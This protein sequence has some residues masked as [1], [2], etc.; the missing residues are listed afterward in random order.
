MY[1]RY[2]GKQIG[3]ILVFPTSGK[4]RAM[5]PGITPEII[6]EE[7]GG[8]VVNILFQ[9]ATYCGRI[10]KGTINLSKL[11]TILPYKTMLEP[12]LFHALTIYLPEGG[13]IINIFSSGK[14]IAMGSSSIHTF[15]SIIYKISNIYV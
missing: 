7:L 3:V 13:S 10:G 8:C 2:L 9:G 14:F 5:G 4:F 1:K 12:E 11:S 6:A 15:N